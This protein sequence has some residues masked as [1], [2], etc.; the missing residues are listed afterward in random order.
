MRKTG[1]SGKMCRCDHDGGDHHR[2]QHGVLRVMKCQRCPCTGF[3][4]KEVVGW[5]KLGWIAHPPS[6]ALS[7]ETPRQYARRNAGR[8]DKRLE[9]VRAQIIQRRPLSEADRG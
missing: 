6:D 7:G 1:P 4:A 3:K 2:E 8:P 9:I 5:Q